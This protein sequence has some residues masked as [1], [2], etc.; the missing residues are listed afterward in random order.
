[1]GVLTEFC[2]LFG[3]PVSYTIAPWRKAKTLTE[4]SQSFGTALSGMAALTLAGIFVI[5]RVLRRDLGKSGLESTG[6]S[7]LIFNVFALTL[8]TVGRSISFNLAPVAP[9]YLFWS[10]LFWTSLILLG[11]KRADR[12]QW[13]RWPVILLPF[14]IAILVWPAH[15]QAWLWCKNAQ[16]LYDEDAIALING[17]VDAQR[18]QTLPP[19]FKQIFQE[20]VLLASQVRARRLDIFADGLQDW[21]GL[22]EADVFGARNKREGLNGQCSIDALGQCDNGAPAARVRGRALKHEQ[23][24]PWTLVIADSNGVIRGVARSARLNPFVNRTFYQGKLTAEIGFVGYIRNYNPELRYVVRS[25]DNL[26]LSD[27]EIPVQH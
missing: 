12:L 23:S 26:T 21:I 9:R 27:E 13:G 15:Y 11:I 17:A 3:S 22:R 5:P 8:I 20:R 14:A 2:R 4:L 6:L 7:L 1:M 24:V 16:V 10:S 19:Q 18:I 25:A